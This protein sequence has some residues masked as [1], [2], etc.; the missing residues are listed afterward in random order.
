MARARRAVRTATG[1]ATVV[2]MASV[3]AAVGVIT[4]GAWEP[5]G[6]SGLL[7][8]GIAADPCDPGRVLPVPP[9]TAG[10][11]EPGSSVL[12]TAAGVLTARGVV[13]MTGAVAGCAASA[14]D[15]SQRWLAAGVVPGTTAQQRAMASR[16]LL[17]L[18]LSVRSDGAAVAGWHGTWQYAWPRD[19]SW[20][21]VA[22]ARTG[23]QAQ[24][25]QILRFL[26]RVQGRDG[27]WA[28]R[29]HLDGTP[30]RDGRPAE[31][32]SAGWVPWAVWSWFTA[33][34]HARDGRGA[35]AGSGP[36]PPGGRDRE[37]AR[38]QLAQLWPMVRGA[39]NAAAG[40]L[41]SGG[42]PVPAMDYW[43]NSTEVTL[44]TAAP[45]LAGLR[46]AA[47]LAPLMRDGHDGRRWAA[48]AT[49]LAAGITSQ[50]G[51]TGY[52][53]TPAAAAGADAAITFLGPPLAAPGR[54]VRMAAQATQ[55]ALRQPN[56][57]LVPGT[58]WRGST[59]VAWTAETAFFALFDAGTGRPGAAAGIL[60]WLASH[61]T[62]LGELPE[63]VN[64]DGRPVAVA[65]LAWT[66]AVVL[67]ALLAESGHLPA[68]PAP[69]A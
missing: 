5:P 45:L 46:A 31:L 26:A 2:A 35:R 14:A 67:L 23:H 65:P 59:G 24:A 41:T 68:V 52:Q 69:H 47:S 53:R 9:G 17:D 21:A 6:A 42:L 33:A 11:F 61:R 22:L 10:H 7:M 8:A 66:D 48:A 25:L 43:E 62:S 28:A 39:A 36:A 12:T 60:S 40:S 30:V 58:R 57:G 20:V 38:S 4:M 19:S 1:R 56:G 15:A 49:R 37:L 55:R 34:E 3:L 64:D 54:A 29:Y 63:Q 50:F 32:D 51:R 44:G 18:R 27:I 16:A 13:P